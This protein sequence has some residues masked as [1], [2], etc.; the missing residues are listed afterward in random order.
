MQVLIFNLETTIQISP[1]FK[2]ALLVGSIVVGVIIGINICCCLFSKYG[3]KTMLNKSKFL[4][5]LETK[6]V[7][8]FQCAVP[9]LALLSVPRLNIVE[10]NYDLVFFFNLSIWKIII[11]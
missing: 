4:L 3:F 5:I 8:R 6:M 9:Q 1:R 11:F 7:N 10:N 2:F